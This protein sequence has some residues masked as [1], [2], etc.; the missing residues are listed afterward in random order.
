MVNSE[1]IK[2]L[3]EKNSSLNTAHWINIE[4]FTQDLLNLLLK[5]YEDFTKEIND[6]I[7]PINFKYRLIKLKY[8]TTKIRNIKN[9]NEQR[10]STSK[11]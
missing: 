4:D 1:Q 3:L 11:T 6:L 8:I 7:E 10:K 9:Q 5:D 2:K